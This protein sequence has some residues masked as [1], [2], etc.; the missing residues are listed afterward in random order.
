MGALQAFQMESR[1]FLQPLL[2][3][4]IDLDVFFDIADH[5][6]RDK[7]FA[8]PMRPE[9]V[10]FYPFRAT[11]KCALCAD[12]TWR[13]HICIRPKVLYIA[14]RDLWGKTQDQECSKREYEAGL[15]T[16]FLFLLSAVFFFAQ[17]C[18]VFLVDGPTPKREVLAT[19]YVCV[20][21]CVFNFRVVQGS[22]HTHRIPGTAEKGVKPSGQPADFRSIN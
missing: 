11:G 14:D 8:I 20:C 22:T 18:F 12:S 5:E 17:C 1:V 3:L 6:N 7:K 21:V 9:T 10:F 15:K 2:V 4:G 19:C 13:L 16:R